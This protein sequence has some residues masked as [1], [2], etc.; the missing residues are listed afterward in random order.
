MPAA[1]SATPRSANDDAGAR[2]AG[3]DAGERNT[4]GPAPPE[5]EAGVA[6]GSGEE[7]DLGEEGPSLTKEPFGDEGVVAEV[8]DEEGV[9]ARGGGDEGGSGE[10]EGDS[11]EEEG[12][13]GEVEEDEQEEE[14]ESETGGPPSEIGGVLQTLRGVA[15]GRDVNASVS[16]VKQVQEASEQ[17]VLEPL[18]VKTVQKIAKVYVRPASLQ[19]LDRSLEAFRGTAEELDSSDEGDGG[20]CRVLVVHGAEHA[21]KLAS[22]LAVTAKLVSK[23][24]ASLFTYR[25]K[26][27]EAG[28]LLEVVRSEKWLPRS[29]VV[30]EDAFDKNVALAELEGAEL[31]QL[32]EVLVT[33]K[34][35]LVLTTELSHEDLKA[36]G[37]PRVFVQVGELREILAKHLAFY[38]AGARDQRQKQVEAAVLD[39]WSRLQDLLNTPFHIDRFC[40]RLRDL[41]SL[42]AASLETLARSVGQADAR[43]MRLWFDGLSSNEKLVAM[44]IYLFEG[45]NAAALEELAS[46]VVFRLRG[47]GFVWVQ[48]PR[49]IG[50]RSLLE[51]VQADG[52]QGEVEF[53][54]AAVRDAV[55]W[56]TLNRQALLWSLLEPIIGETGTGS[57]WADPVRRAALG[58]AVGRMGLTDRRK[59]AGALDRWA[60]SRASLPRRKADSVASLA[61][62]AMAEAL[63]R[64]PK[65]QAGPVVAKIRS[66]IGSKDPDLVWA[67]GAAIWRI[68]IA[69]LGQG[70]DDR[71]PSLR[72]ELKEQLR[73]LVRVSVD[74]GGET[75]RRIVAEV[76]ERKLDKQT[77]RKEVGRRLYELGSQIRACA[78]YALERIGRADLAEM[79]TMLLEWMED[80]DQ[81]E[82]RRVV[83]V[84]AQRTFKGLIALDVEPPREKYL[85][86]LRLIDRLF[87]TTSGS[88][89]VCRDLC[90]WLSAWLRWEGW[91]REISAALLEV[92]NRGSGRARAALREAMSQW[93][94]QGASPAA[95]AIARAVIAR[96]Y[97]MDGIITDR[98]VL[99]RC[100]LVVD[101]ALLAVRASGAPTKVSPAELAARRR[102][103]LLR[104]QASI[105]AQ[106][107]VEVVLL[108]AAAGDEPGDEEPAGLASS[109]P[110]VHRLL[111]PALEKVAGRA[112]RL[113]L[114]V[115]GGPVVDLEDALDML[116]AAGKILVAADCDLDPPPGV[117]LV[118]VSAELSARDIDRVEA[119]LR[120]LWAQTLVQLQPASWLPLLEEIGVRAVDLL[121]VEDS[122]DAWADRLVE[123]ATAG[124]RTDLAKRI[125]SVIL[126]LA[127]G[128]FERCLRIVRGW[129]TADEAAGLQR[130]LGV[131]A[132]RALFHAGAYARSAGGRW[133]PLRLFDELAEPLARSGQDGT[134]AVLRAV[135]QWL[136]IPDLAAGLAGGVEEGRGRLLRWAE[137]SAPH[138]VESFQAAIER[139]RAA[140]EREEQEELGSVSEAL[141]SVLERMR[142]RFNI[143]RPLPTLEAGER[144]GVIV[145]DAAANGGGA[146]RRSQLAGGLCRL[147]NGNEQPA[148][149]PILFRL[150]ERWPA[151]VAGDLDPKVDELASAP[152]PWPRL[153][154][155][156][157]GSGLSLRQVAF[158]LVLAD[159]SWIDGED[160]VD[161]PWRD[162]LVTWRSLSDVPWGAALSSLP[163]PWGGG[164]EEVA[165]AA[166]YLR[167]IVS[168]KEPSH[169]D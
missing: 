40:D 23:A 49:E 134:D 153:L 116:G 1:G 166:R 112:V 85:P 61:G 73:E 135:E 74:L 16:I 137:A 93:W 60:R 151:W 92:A 19:N 162:R 11:E 111:T 77:T 75:H 24:G 143:G 38:G 27:H 88:S 50:F 144:Y 70:M 25:R 6:A 18:S 69:T 90:G 17:Y 80:A 87:A 48:D 14:E 136:E 31:D 107:E 160:W 110:F 94:L 99:G 161:S 105:E 167:R 56:Q 124:G 62:V 33:K 101:P 5:G 168:A 95:E 22:G 26:P 158:V 108:G 35:Y 164:P 139:L 2:S 13:D 152:A 79:V 66:W 47:E 3:N 96:S 104:L 140:M 41:A 127:A 157:L 125:V 39:G 57:M 4:D 89:A 123:P 54:D 109:A 45:L 128:D 131:A 100:I 133:A 84:A 141:A 58:T 42:D 51:A 148:V 169:D 78:V 91:L 155:P 165:L 65:A 64:A 10:G 147:L 55:A 7:D 86:L 138:K 156:I 36:I 52:E 132:G 29:L 34:S 154:S 146:A 20:G 97:A 163:E 53:E 118:R 46:Q 130:A 122:L 30:L 120:T 68:Y 129:L 115:T 37:A 82:V 126:W 83:L 67:A 98:P 59:L 12:E 102:G 81:Q 114:V 149:K 76:R 63:R 150:G 117:G 72:A 43:A 121:R 103:S 145:L 119:H 9:Y 159:T 21:G 106:M 28:S 8:G 15:A 113:V 44:L 71:A 142:S 32:T